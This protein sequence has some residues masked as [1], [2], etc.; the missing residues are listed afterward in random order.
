MMGRKSL[1]FSFAIGV[2]SGALI[3]LT[4]LHA[5]HA[6]N[7]AKR[8]GWETS[9]EWNS[10]S[11]QERIAYLEGY[12]GGYNFGSLDA[13]G[14]A[15]RL[16]EIKGK[17]YM[18]DGTPNNPVMLCMDS[19]DTFKKMGKQGK[20]P[21]NYSSFS[22]AITDFYKKY[23][24]YKN[25]P[26]PFLIRLMSDKNNFSTPEQLFQKLERNDMQATF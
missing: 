19:R 3:S 18:K 1:L 25:A 23:P 4:L 6:S 10:F 12:V 15:D 24:K 21:A 20:L 8:D 9:T 7:F 11:A 14:N 2:L 26:F 5:L 17:A 22:E 13:C 16:F